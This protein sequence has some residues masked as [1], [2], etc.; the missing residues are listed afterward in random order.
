VAKPPGNRYFRR[1]AET[2]V[3]ETADL[4]EERRVQT[5]QLQRIATVFSLA[6]AIPL[7]APGCLSPYEKS[8]KL[9]EAGEYQ[10]ARSELEEGLEQNPD[11]P[12]L[13]VLMAKI[14]VAEEDYR[15]AE[16]YALKAFKAESTR[17]PAGRVLGKIHW[18]LGRAL[19]AVEVWR[20]SRAIDPDYVSEKDFER[21]L[22][23]A[24]GTA[25][26]SHKYERAL[27]LRKELAAIAPDH[28][29]V[30][31]EV[32]QKTRNKYA[33]DLVERGEYEEAA[34]VYETLVEN[35]EAPENFAYERGRVL[36]RL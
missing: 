29:E 10:S 36:L 18:E 7:C 33:E 32:L 20:D 25:D 14:L 17:G 27:E 13:N 2:G 6:V 3:I 26:S 11:D 24:I 35:A 22:V 19:E 30:S 34:A 31:E 16:S 5:M 12:Q 15:G 23:A 28:P 9:Y 8:S 21:A 4:P 1:A